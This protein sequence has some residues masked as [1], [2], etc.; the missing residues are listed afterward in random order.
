MLQPGRKYEAGSGYRFGFNGKEND[1]EVSGEGNQYD[2]GFRI[3]NPRIGRFLSVDPITATYPS[4]TPYQ[5]AS[6]RTIDG[7]DLD[8]LEFVKGL[9][10]ITTFPEFRAAAE[11]GQVSVENGGSFIG[12]YLKGYMSMGAK[13]WVAPITMGAGGGAV[14]AG[15][16]TLSFWNIFNAVAYNPIVQTEIVGGLASLVGF[17]GPEIPGPGS[18]VGATVK[19][20]WQ[21]VKIIKQ[22][23]RIVSQ[24]IKA[25]AELIMHQGASFATQAEKNMVKK[26]LSE[27]NA[28]EILA[29]SN[30]SGVRSADYLINGI[31][32]ELKTLSNIKKVDS[33]HLS[34]KVS[35][36]LKQSKGQASS[37]ILDVTGQEGASQ[38]VIERG[39]K[40]YWKQNESV[41]EV[42]VVGN[43]YEKSYK[44][45]E[46]YPSEN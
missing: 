2:Y 11:S 14:V 34:N 4:L 22:N 40:R 3:Y 29:E 30:E 23:G 16:R 41:Q 1:K 6:N 35:Q 39:L 7:I 45:S 15:F 38:E 36:T 26:L 28:V 31:K 27:G 19:L 37:V 17:E 5:F 46:F 13:R 43:G 12:G 21:E 8:G 25:T 18:R 20:T 24:E 32:T 9:F 33:D 44:K 42:K 10:P